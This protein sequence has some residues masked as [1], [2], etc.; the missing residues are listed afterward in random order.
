MELDMTKLKEIFD[1]SYQQRCCIVVDCDY[2]TLRKFF[3]TVIP[4][5]WP[6]WNRGQKS[7]RPY[8]YYLWK[9]Y[10]TEYRPTY[11]EL[12]IIYNSHHYELER[13]GYCD[14]EYY[15][16]V[17]YALYPKTLSEIINEVQLQIDI[18]I[19]DLL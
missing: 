1:D 11:R 12:A 7:I 5:L 15:R 10:I 4:V 6:W 17:G 2:N 14:T 16:S 3:E 9:S 8:A 13:F 18:D 19:L